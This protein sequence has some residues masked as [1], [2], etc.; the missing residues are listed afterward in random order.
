MKILMKILKMS[1]MSN[2]VI[3]LKDNNSKEDNSNKKETKLSRK[4][5]TV[6][7]HLYKDK[8]KSQ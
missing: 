5:Q 2:K 6:T 1:S 8:T 3:S 4:I 7:L